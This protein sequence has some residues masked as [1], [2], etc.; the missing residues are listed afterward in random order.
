MKSMRILVMFGAVAAVA[1]VPKAVPPPEPRPEP[2]PQ[3]APPP[4]P[5]PAADWRDIP[6]TPGDWAYSAQGS[7]SQAVFG[8]VNGQPL[9]AVRCDRGQRQIIL[10]RSGQAGGNA[11]TIRTTFGDRNLPVAAG[12]NPA[13]AALP[14]NDRFLDDMV[15]SRGRITVEVP[16]TAMLVIPTWPAPAR[17][18]EDC[19][20]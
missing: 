8:P 4:P 13:A 20:S 5:P 9:F 10:S 19:R 16:G 11:M 2:A 17:V 1:C 14:V 18:I 6:L 3:P 7:A 12:A 15:F